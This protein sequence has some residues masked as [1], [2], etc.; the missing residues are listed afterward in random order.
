MD[1]RAWPEFG[2]AA[3]VDMIAIDYD[4]LRQAEFATFPN[5]RRVMF[6]GHGAGEL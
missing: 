6:L 1:F 2:E 4:D 3:D 5:F